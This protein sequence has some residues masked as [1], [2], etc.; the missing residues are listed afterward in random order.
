MLR[1]GTNIY[2]YLAGYTNSDPAPLPARLRKMV[3]RVAPL[4]AKLWPHVTIALCRRE[5]TEVARMKVTY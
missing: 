4:R 1:Y 3:G 2:R 5:T